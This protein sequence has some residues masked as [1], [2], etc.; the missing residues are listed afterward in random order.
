MTFLKYLMLFMIALVIVVVGIVG[1][2]FFTAKVTVADCDITG[3][4]A[5]TQPD[6]FQQVNQYLSLGAFPGVIFTD[7]GLGEAAD[8]AFITYTL[9]LSN[10][11]LI[12]IE[13]IEVQIVPK[14]G[15]ILQ[16]GDYQIHKLAPKTSGT[17]SATI[18]TQKDSHSVREV[19]ITYYVWGVS[20]TITTT[21]G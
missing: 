21:C 18:L 13:M 17:V 10:Q 19:L 6:L 7:V 12:P 9:E 1:Y 14:D 3:H 5:V 2:F 20:Y 11:C 15:D 4:A 8:Y 16:L